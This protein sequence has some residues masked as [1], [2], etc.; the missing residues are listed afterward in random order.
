[1]Q[2]KLQHSWRSPIIFILIAVMMAALFFS[3]AVLSVSMIVFVVVSF[4]HAD[5]KKHFSNFFSSPLL[6][7]MSLLFFLPL[8]SGLWTED[9]K[10]W[11]DIIRIKLP[12]LVLPLAFAGPPDS[13]RDQLS[14]KQWEWVGCIFIAL[15]TAGTCWS[16]FHYLSDAA[17]INE[18]YLRAKSIVTP[19]ENDHV[20]F[21]WLVCVCVLLAGWLCLIKRQENKLVSY[22]LAIVTIWLI[23]FLHILAIRT[24]LFSFYIIAAGIAV[25]LIAKK[26]QWK[27]GLCL[28]LLLLALPL[29]AYKIL[30]T[31]QNR[32]QYFLHDKGYFE[33]AH[34]LP[35]AT[36]AVRVI[37]LRAG[38][39]VTNQQ[40]VNGVGFGDVLTK[41]KQW[42]GE[43]YPQMI[44]A[45]KIYPSSE[46]LMY[47]AGCGWPGLLLFTI[48]MCIPFVIK[49][50]NRL[51][52]WLLNATAAFSFLFD[53]S[54]E[55]QFGVFIYSF[56]I[57]WWWK[58]L[59]VE[60]V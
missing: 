22:T 40:P 6:W 44:E 8:L 17:A 13:Y 31:F 51:L 47:G 37:S 55:V 2:N 41:T 12:L 49:T 57:L 32:V 34:Y 46:W 60:K 27:Y 26:L 43:N 45:D 48:I 7:G 25:Y 30:P 3:R 9:K 38:W 10:E 24:G 29:I 42:Y 50:T 19:L 23:V 15:V 1:M 16:M 28:L 5:I 58:W 33:K 35:G 53:I 18:S 39:N 20:R 11:A 52:W 14:K 59:K 56:I 54:L 21:S 36:D 4:F